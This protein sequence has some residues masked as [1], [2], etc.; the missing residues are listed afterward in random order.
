[1]GEGNLRGAHWAARI[2]RTASDMMPSPAKSLVW[3]VVS[4]LGAINTQHSAHAKC[5]HGPQSDQYRH[6]VLLLGPERS[7]PPSPH[8]EGGHGSGGHQYRPAVLLP[9]AAHPQ[10]E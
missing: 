4:V 1:M 8:A 9:Q 2:A 7:S 3:H 5:F 6:A 10:A